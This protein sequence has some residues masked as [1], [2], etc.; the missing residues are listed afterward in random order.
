MKQILQHLKTGATEL[1]DVPAPGAEVGHL[2]IRTRRSIISLGT[3]RMLA[4]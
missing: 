1:V 3:E 2:L 4:S